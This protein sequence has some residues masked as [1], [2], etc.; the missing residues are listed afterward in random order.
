[1]DEPGGG[2]A[3]IVERPPGIMTMSNMLVGQLDYVYFF[4]GLALLLLGAVC[5]SM[6]RAG[7][8]PTPWWLLGAFAITH[9]S[10]EWLRLVALTGGDSGPFSFFRTVLV[11]ASFLF[12][13]EFARRTH[14]VVH[15]T[16]VSPWLHVL[17]GGVLSGLA[18]AFGPA[19]IESAVRP[20]IAA[21]AVFWTAGLF[22]T[23]AARN[24]ALGGGSGSRRARQW[25]AA[26]FGAFGLAAG[27][28]VPQA[29]FLPGTWLSS[30]AFLELTGVPIELV[31]GL[32]VWGMALS[33][34][35]LAVS[36]DSRGSVSRKRRMLFWV[37]AASLVVLL[38]GGWLFTDRLGKLHEKDILQDAESSSVLVHEHLLDE[39]RGAEG[40]ARAM[41][42]LLGR[43]DV[44]EGALV[45]TRLDD[46]V[47]SI[48]LASDG[49]VAY[50]ID[51]TGRT[52]STSNRGQPD[53]FLG[54]NFSVR[55]YFKEA[56]RGRPDRFLGVG[57]VSGIAGYY[58][59]EPVRGADG[60]VVAVAV[61]KCNLTAEQLGPAGT[62]D[63]SIVS[64]EGRILVSSVEGRVNRLLW[65]AGN[66]RGSRTPP[67][68]VA[69]GA[70]PAVLG[71]PVVGT[72]WVS[73]DGRKEIAV[74]KPIPG[75]DWSLVVLKREKAQVANR[76]LG[77]V[78]TLLLC[79][80]VLTYFVAM[81]RQY[82]AE[83][84][85]AGKRREAEG[86]ARE[87]ERKADSDALTGLLNRLGF[88]GAFSREFERSRRYGHPLSVVILD[89]D[90]F[91]RVNDEHGHVAG[92]QVL[93]G[94]ARLIETGTRESDLLA[95]WGG[96][97]FV[98][99]AAMTPEKGA[100]QLAEKLR[101]RLAATPLGP[102]GAV[103]GSFGVAELRPGESSEGLLDRADAAL[104]RA[105]NGGRN[106]VECAEAGADAAAPAAKA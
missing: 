67:P 100:L 104:Y 32:L 72:E 10:A 75:S 62:N 4:Y 47:D 27:L 63:A 5:L 89:L 71:H 18:L 95:R 96:E 41:A 88:N 2:E 66:G 87:F 12:L 7:P 73:V 55:P 82:G 57:L 36:L 37:M 102:A 42:K 68:G 16:T 35:A 76:L 17:L 28:V 103:T 105:K 33:I 20:V 92:D 90:H 23:A 85:I 48:A 50:V 54:K 45:T 8:L 39:M 40:G 60:R 59:S 83:A 15:G 46:I 74:G 80:V 91:K 34:W 94:V 70:A 43:L 30:E 86:R 69:P 13:L 21:P 31:R 106:R 52:I 101:V 77:I 44:A 1:M 26:S 93:V 84:H 22:L 98:V 58:A 53:S 6:P 79:A 99:V 38:A 97:E 65:S 24:Q 14:R 49:W 3:D 56:V 19:H 25:G 61:V 51:P 29:P 11:G 9:G 64:A 81:Q 78:I